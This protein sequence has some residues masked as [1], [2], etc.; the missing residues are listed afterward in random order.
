MKLKE[1]IIKAL[2]LGT[3]LAIGMLLK[4]KVCYEMSHDKCYSD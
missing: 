1:T 2:A 3:G 4:A